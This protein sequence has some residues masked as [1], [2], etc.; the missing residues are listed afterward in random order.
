MIGRYRILRTLGRGAMGVVYE[1]HDEAIDRRVAIKIVRADLLNGDERD[2]FLERFQ[3]EARAAGRCN[4]PSIV[5]LYDFALHD[6][7]PYLAMEYVDGVGLDSAIAE[8]G[9]QRF[10]PASA[11]H[12]TL[13][14]LD[15]LASAHAAGIVHRDVKPANILLVDGDRLK[16][17]DFGIARLENVSLTMH[18]MSVGS[19]RYMS[20]E[21]WQGGRADARSDLFSTAVLLQEM[22]TGEHPFS[23][24]SSNEILHNIVKGH[25]TGGDRLIEVVGP[26]ITAV[27]HRA[28]ATQ[29]EDRFASARDMAEALRRATDSETT[30]IETAPGVSLDQT[31]IAVRSHS[32]RQPAGVPAATTL[33]PSR[34]SS[35]ERQLAQHVGPIAHYLVQSSLKNVNSIEDLCDELAQRIDRPEERSQFLT[36]ALHSARSMRAGSAGIRSKSSGSSSSAAPAPVV[37]PPDAISAISADEIEDA[38]KALAKSQGPIAKILVKRTLAKAKSADELWTL[39]A[40]EIASG[41]DRAEFLRQKVR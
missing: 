31:V 14:L 40:A 24:R 36:S 4:H 35:I 41:V 22:L 23:G 12:V 19:P 20:P 7:N 6:G 27:I 15:A 25:P 11:V 34:V 13:E 33:D 21:Q 16:V 17:T 30:R 3:Q 38:R 18:G 39:L 29:P 28:L 37:D 26:A 9:E 8:A 10:A 5:A 2:D 1:A 32:A